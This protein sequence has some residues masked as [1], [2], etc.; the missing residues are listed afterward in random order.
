VFCGLALALP[1]GA[2]AAFPDG[3]PDENPRLDTP[4]DPDFDRCE[5]DD[6]DV[7]PDDQD[8]Q[9]NSYFEEQ[10]GLFGFGP[11]AANQVPG[12]GPHYLTGTRYSDCSQLDEAG[13]RANVRAEGVEGV[14]VAEDLAECL[15]ISG[16]RADQ[17]WKRSTGDPDTVIAILDTG[18]R[19]QE[20]E[21]VD[22]IAL[23]REELETPQGA[24]GTPC[25]FDCNGDGA[26]SV[27]DYADDPRVGPAD[28]DFEADELL[29]ASDLIAVFSDDVDD[30][31]DGAGNGYVD[32]IA[33]WDF[34]D[35]DNDPF[36]ISSC[37]SA[38]GHGTGRALEAAAETDNALAGAGVC[39]ECQVMPLRVWDT[40]VVP[41]DFFAMGVVY[42]AD[43]GASVVEGAVGG[44]TNTRFARDAFTYADEQG[45]ALTL[46]S[47]DINSANHNYPTNYNEAIYVAGSFPD[48]AP[49]D[50]CQGPGGLPGLPDLP[51]APG[52]FTAGCN[53]LLDLLEAGTGCGE[54][55]P[56]PT[57][58]NPG[59]LGQPL[60]TSFFRNSNL[61]QYGG[62]SDIVLE[63]TT[64]SQNTGQASGAAGLLASYGRQIFGDD[65]PLSGNEIR[66]LL[67]MTAED[68]L[69]DNTGAIGLPDKANDGWD[70]HFGYGRVNL[71][72]ALK[73]IFDDR[74]PPEA[75]IDA[76][77]W[78]AP[79]N[80]DRLSAGVPIFGRAAAPH[81]AGVGAW[82]LEYA[83][84]Q[85]AAD[86]EFVLVPGA[87]DS[88]PIDGLLGTL[89]VPL[90]ENLADTCDGDVE[91]DFGRPSGTADQAPGDPYPDPDP[92]RH[93]F[94]IRLTVHEEGDMANVGRYRKT[95]HAYRD[96]GN[97]PDWPRP[98]GDRS[99]AQEFTTGSGGE[100]SPRLYDFDGDNALDVIQ[101]DSSGALRVL[102]S[103]GRPVSAFNDG[104]PVRTAPYAVAENHGVPGGLDPP[105]E[106]LRVPAIG[107]IDGDEAAEIVATAGEHVYAW[108]LDGDVVE[109]FPTR[110]DPSLSDPCVPPASKPCF[111]QGERAIT[112]DNHIKRG[113]FGSPALADL[114][115]DGVLDIVTGA[116]DQ[117]LYA[118]DGEGNFLEPFPVK[119]DSPD[120]DGAEIVTSPAIADLTGDGDPE[121]VISTNE[122]VPGDPA[123]PTNLFDLFNAVLASSTGSNLV[124]AIEGDGSPAAGD[125]PVEV[126]VASGDILPLVVPGHDSAV[127]DEDD[128][129]ADEVS[130]S[131]A[132]SIVPG[133]SRLV[134]GAGQTVSVYQHGVSDRADPGPV[135]NLADYTSIGDLTGDGSPF[136]LKGGLSLN[137]AA[138]LLAVNQNLAF[139]HLE[140]AWDPGDGSSVTGYPVATDDFQLVSQGSIAR[141]A[142]EGPGRQVLVGTGLYN[143]H[144][145]EADGS[146][147]PGEGAERW[148]K[149][150][151]GWL[152]ATPAIGDMDGDG[153]LDIS[154]MTREGWQFAWD[155]G[156]DACDGSND[157][158]WGFHHDE[159]AT[160]NYGADGRPPGTAAGLEATRDEASGAVTFSWT[161]P[162]DDWLC[163]TADRYRVVLSDAPISEPSEGERVA[164]EEASG[165]PGEEAELTLG[166]AALGGATRAGVYYLDEAGNYGLVAD[167]ALPERGGG[168][169]PDPDGPCA[170]VINGTPGSDRLPGTPGADRIRGLGGRDRMAGRA[171]DDCL[172]GGSGKDRVRGGAGEDKLRGG[173][174]R[175]RLRSG[176][177]DDLVRAGGKGKDRVNCGPGDDT[178]VVSRRDRVRGCETIKRR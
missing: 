59:V 47:S 159:R 112:S 2:L 124:Y 45:L 44:L 162:G 116:M 50:G 160:A 58:I 114:D 93:A 103:E 98:L 46:V 148:P 82:E 22:K 165:A 70:P 153:D 52:D 72:A 5:G 68:V 53:E 9:C 12:L 16:I 108:E 17:A 121:V 48:T 51:D 8:A 130:V 101:G 73:R 33:G 67:T 83:C 94:Q 169:G 19:W 149:F 176:A 135:I 175:D 11:D 28:G 99:S 26:F 91:S 18:I 42:A 7:P 170:N 173:A 85:D 6:S 4:S 157:E 35:D 60:T 145:Y 140:Q 38:S 86:S 137:G 10:F 138:N 69:P 127:L 177:G 102:D 131:A 113:F 66:Q 3:P 23:N 14:P 111:E 144:A 142:G 61:T 123:F 146:E 25:A 167:V 54:V 90:L 39:P 56:A 178:A 71:P 115:E 166:D 161:E 34:F 105:R 41:T 151:G 152:Q 110:L 55:P 106:S 20:R 117:H 132:T 84:G 75:Q 158:W 97:L 172:G 107:D 122:Q 37:C 147:A 125:W 57:C 88:G 40:F 29:D 65:D 133:G 36:D 120:A 62:K 24:G 13:K 118:Y 21:L 171:G 80:V 141:V 81:G 49:N 119:L 129:G 15:Q 43:N 63:A 96:D 155:T 79:I 156:V 128:D 95:L 92:E 78:F 143:L 100:V 74:V 109:G 154:T 134:D 168:P 164:D 87:T 163:G 1:A 64:G 77:D 139:N 136:V 126:G 104:Q 150:A 174:G 89:S 27:S 30:D 76:P 32:D 31:D